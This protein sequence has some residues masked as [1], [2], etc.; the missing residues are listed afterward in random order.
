MLESVPTAPPG[1]YN[2][3]MERLEEDMEKR[4]AKRCVPKAQMDRR[5]FC[6]SDNG[7]RPVCHRVSLTSLLWSLRLFH[8][9]GVDKAGEPECHGDTDSQGQQHQEGVCP[10]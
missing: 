9:G 1:K 6:V 2:G 8:Q 7:K 5:C 4:A 3:F 10:L